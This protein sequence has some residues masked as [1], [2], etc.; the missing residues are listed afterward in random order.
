[1]CNQNINDIEIIAGD[2]CCYQVEFLNEDTPY[3]I[4]EGDVIEMIIH[5]NGGDRH[6]QAMSTENNIATFYLSKEYTHSLLQN[7]MGCSYRYCIAIT[8]SNGGHYTPIYR[9]LLKVKR[10]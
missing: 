10:C 5:G 8:Y 4:Q 2:D 1:M 6:I 3:I 9:Q 7:N